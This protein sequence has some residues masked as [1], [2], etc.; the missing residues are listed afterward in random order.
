MPPSRKAKRLR[1]QAEGGT[2][3]FPARAAPVAAYAF[4]KRQPYS[5]RP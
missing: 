2:P 1:S 5:M 4:L 3:S